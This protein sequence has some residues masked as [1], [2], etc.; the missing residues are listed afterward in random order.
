MVGLAGLM[1]RSPSKLGACSSGRITVVSARE[2]NFG[3]AIATGPRDRGSTHAKLE[4]F[5]ISKHT[6]SLF[7][8]VEV[9]STQVVSLA[10]GCESE[11]RNM[12]NQ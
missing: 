3:N 10:A 5:E 8:V 9:D 11:S 12:T 6:G 4:G 1:R 2:E 7:N